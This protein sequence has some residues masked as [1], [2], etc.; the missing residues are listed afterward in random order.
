SWTTNWSAIDH[1]AVKGFSKRPTVWPM[2]H[3]DISDHFPVY[4]KIMWEKPLP[5]E[6]KTIISRTKVKDVR[7]QF[8]E[9]EKPSTMRAST[10]RRVGRGVL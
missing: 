8:V 3:W 6:E 9:D 10:S 5:P 7:P 4:V 1:M 2:Q